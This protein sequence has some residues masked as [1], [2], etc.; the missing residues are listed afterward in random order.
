MSKYIPLTEYIQF[1]LGLYTKVTSYSTLSLK[2]S[3]YTLSDEI[4]PLQYK[5][6]LDGIKTIQTELL[7]RLFKYIYPIAPK[8]QKEWDTKYD[9][10]QEFIRFIKKLVT[11]LYDCD[12]SIDILCYRFSVNDL[13]DLR[14][15]LVRSHHYSRA[16]KVKQ[17][18]MFFA[19]D[20]FRFKL[21]ILMA[22]KSKENK[23]MFNNPE[24]TSQDIESFL[25]EIRSSI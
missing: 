4:T 17:E 8:N 5:V 25:K 11:S 6:E 22:K 10:E 15:T 18:V 19:W 12:K 14:D 16:L 13:L 9:E 20:Y 24:I 7:T 3:T 21:G 1:K 2:E 23:S